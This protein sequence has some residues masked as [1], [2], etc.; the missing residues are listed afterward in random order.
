MDEELD[1]LIRDLNAAAA[2]LANSY[3]LTPEAKEQLRATAI[4]GLDDVHR[5]LGDW[6]DTHR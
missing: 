6:I 4:N 5:R 2:D 3:C 1:A